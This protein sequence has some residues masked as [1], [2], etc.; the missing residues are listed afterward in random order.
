[1]AQR[2][3]FHRD[4][5]VAAVESDGPTVPV[6]EPRTHV[7]GTSQRTRLWW[8]TNCGMSERNKV[9]SADTISAHP[10]PRLQVQHP[11]AARVV[12]ERRVRSGPATRA[13]TGN[14]VRR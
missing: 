14:S 8:G 9:Q 3:E 13:R 7:T 2:F 6:E 12:Q 1:M 5:P 10:R 4:Q 11:L